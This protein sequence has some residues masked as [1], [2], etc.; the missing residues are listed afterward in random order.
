M[1]GCASVGESCTCSPGLADG[2]VSQ[3]QCR[4]AEGA[5]HGQLHLNV[6]VTQ[7]PMKEGENCMLPHARPRNRHVAPRCCWVQPPFCG[8]LNA[9]IWRQESPGPGEAEDSAPCAESALLLPPIP[10]A[11]PTWAAKGRGRVSSTTAHL[12]FSPSLGRGDVLAMCPSTMDMTISRQCLTYENDSAFR[13][14]GGGRRVLCLASLHFP[15][16][17]LPSVWFPDWVT[18]PGE[19]RQPQPHTVT[20]RRMLLASWVGERSCLQSAEDRIN[21]LFLPN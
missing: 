13:T 9:A 20:P 17:E 11:S 8:A 5:G 12:V 1:R 7:G 3:Q 18:W 14:G 16:T 10:F 2:N 4:G 21:D 19:C 6:R 15:P